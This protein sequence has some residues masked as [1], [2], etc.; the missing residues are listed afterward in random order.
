MSTASTNDD[1]EDE[2]DDDDDAMD[3]EGLFHDQNISQNTKQKITIKK[4]SSVTFL[5]NKLRFD[6]RILFLHSRLR[7]NM[8]L[9]CILSFLKEFW[10]HN[11]YFPNHQYCHKFGNR[12]SYQN[13]LPK[14]PLFTPRRENVIC[15]DFLTGSGIVFLLA[16]EEA[17]MLEKDAVS[18][19]CY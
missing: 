13:W 19:S 12:L 18:N 7:F 9:L 5:K 3:M 17:G 4:N 2:E 8:L 6:S 11:F 10:C 14:A 1:D 15:F 16:F